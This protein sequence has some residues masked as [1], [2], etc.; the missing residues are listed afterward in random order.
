MQV[1]L[2]PFTSGISSSDMLNQN[3]CET[4]RNIHERGINQ[5][6]FECLHC[7]G[8]PTAFQVMYCSE[9]CH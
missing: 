8:I 4:A 3:D 7:R 9:V 5:G 1:I 2:M 6:V